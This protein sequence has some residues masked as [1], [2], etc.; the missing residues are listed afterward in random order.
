M[1]NLR[2]FWFQFE[3]LPVP[4]PLNLGCGVTAYSRNDAISLLHER[5]FGA[6]DLP[7]LI[8]VIE[9]VSI[10]Q[11][12]HKHVRPNLGNHLERGIWFPQG[13]DA[14]IDKLNSR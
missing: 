9:D 4:T 6:D 1:S 5:V 13:Y 3:R 8:N 12:E 10:S 14:P 2:R 11:L 7:P